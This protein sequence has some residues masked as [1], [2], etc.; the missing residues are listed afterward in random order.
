MSGFIT[1]FACPLSMRRILSYVLTGL[2]IVAGFSLAFTIV[3][4]LVAKDSDAGHALSER[5]MPH[6]SLILVISIPALIV[7]F[8][9]HYGRNKFFKKLRK[10]EEQERN[11][12]K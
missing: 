3:V 6:M 4:V 9:F 2:A 1:K 5:W 10:E 7:W 12:M 11:K 8:V